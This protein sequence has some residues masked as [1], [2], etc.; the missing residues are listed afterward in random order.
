MVEL[1]TVVLECS[2][3]RKHVPPWLYV[4]ARNAADLTVLDDCE[5]G[6]LSFL[7]GTAESYPAFILSDDI[8]AVVSNMKCECG[9]TTDVV[10]IRRRVRRI[11]ERG[12]ALRMSARYEASDRGSGRDLLE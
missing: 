10:E 11:E 9:R 2:A 5:E 4:R 12:C 7:D 3:K 1:N 6:V 8:G